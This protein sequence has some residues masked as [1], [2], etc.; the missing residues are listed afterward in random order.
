VRNF[1]FLFFSLQFK[2][3][4]SKKHKKNRENHILLSTF[5]KRPNQEKLFNKKKNSKPKINKNSKEKFKKIKDKVKH[6]K[7]TTIFTS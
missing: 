7:K 5:K 3:I 2:K 4:N 6:K 1:I